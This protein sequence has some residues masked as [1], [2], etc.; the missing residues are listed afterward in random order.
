MDIQMKRAIFKT[1]RYTLPPEA[2]SDPSGET[3][4]VFK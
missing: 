1:V 2:Q 3:V 4:T